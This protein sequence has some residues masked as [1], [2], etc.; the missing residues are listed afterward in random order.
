MQQMPPQHKVP[1]Q[2]QH[3]FYD[4][5]QAQRQSQQ[6]YNPQHA[7]QSQQVSDFNTVPEVEQEEVRID[8]VAPLVLAI[9]ALFGVW[10]CGIISL[11]WSSKNMRKITPEHRKYKRVRTAQMLA[12][13]A[14]ILTLI[15]VIV[16]LVFAFYWWQHLQALFC[17]QGDEAFCNTATKLANLLK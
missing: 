7:Q 5:Q 1:P 15:Y 16:S 3:Q 6:F 2:Q 4:P 13:L 14:L 10:P 17:E 12:S 8:A 9:I 11:I